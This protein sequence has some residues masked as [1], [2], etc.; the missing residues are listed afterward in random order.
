[1]LAL[2][3]KNMILALLKKQRIIKASRLLEYMPDISKMTLWRDIKKLENEGLIKRLHGGLMLNEIEDEEKIECEDEFGNRIK[4]HVEE[5]KSIAEKAARLVKE[6]ETI[7]LDAGTTSYYVANIIK[8]IPNIKIITNNVEI[9]SSI[10]FASN[11]EVLLTGGLLTRETSA[12][13]GPKAIDFF[14]DFVAD[15]FFFSAAGFDIKKGVLDINVS[16][17][18][19][20][21]AML[22]VSRRAV[23]LLDYSKFFNQGNYIIAKLE[24]LYYIITDNHKISR[25]TVETF[26]PKNINVL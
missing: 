23:L 5:K 19:I 4:I 18:E 22:K 1:M 26:K 21:K 12:L 9:A 2:E 3:R 10:R 6:G 16:A 24:D 17:V 8:N 14:N 7:I 11:I 25:Q 13:V 20:K 15:W